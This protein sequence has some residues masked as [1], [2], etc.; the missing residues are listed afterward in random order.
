VWYGEAHRARLERVLQLRAQGLSVEEIGRRLAADV[1]ASDRALAAALAG[2]DAA[3]GTLLTLDEL[4]ERTG[5]SKAVLEAVERQGL[6]VPRT[7][8]GQPRYTAAD[9]ETV[10]AGLTLLQAGV[11]LGEL[12]DIA[13]R[14]DAAM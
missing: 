12:L 1:E 6:L 3:D 4:A 9:V 14:H 11:P 8:D 2:P 13:R 7:V 5:V 10:R